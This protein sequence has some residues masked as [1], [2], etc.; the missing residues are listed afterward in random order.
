M[1]SEFCF[2]TPRDPKRG[3]VQSTWSATSINA[4]VKAIQDAWSEIETFQYYKSH[5]FL[6]AHYDDEHELT[7]KVAE[8]L[9]ERLDGAASGFFRKEYFQ[10]V[11]RDGK[12]STA[13]LDSTKKMP[14][15]AFRLT[16][17]AKGEDREESA[18]FVEAKLIDA[19]SGCREYVINGL[20]RFVTGEYAP[21]MSFGMMLGYC[22][23]NFNNPAEQLPHYFAEATHEAAK[24]CVAT[25]SVNN[26][27]IA[28]T[29]HSRAA[30]SATNFR[31]LHLWVVRP[32]TNPTQIMLKAS[33]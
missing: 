17:T 15:L 30:P 3:P 13:T 25:V 20:H 4:V 23:P 2:F 33:R 18:L 24:L 14:D 28:T 16:K 21:Q 7:T 12:Q 32:A 26:S 19:R 6:P 22:K 11:I 29:D 9:N 8:I 1:S 5:S 10:V 31:A 27:G